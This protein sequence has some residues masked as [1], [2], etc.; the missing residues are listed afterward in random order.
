MLL[1]VGHN[2]KPPTHKF[3]VSKGACSTADIYCR[4]LLLILLI[5]L[6][7]L[8]YGPIVD[9]DLKIPPRPPG[10]AF[11]EVICCS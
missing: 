9:I 10:Y 11:V 6:L 5:R 1:L 3:L 7:S 4:S 8:Q 2:S